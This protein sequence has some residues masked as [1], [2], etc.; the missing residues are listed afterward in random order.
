M[1]KYNWII[2]D[3]TGTIKF[4]AKR[5][6]SFD[7]AEEYLSAFF[8]AEGMDYEEWR[9]EYYIIKDES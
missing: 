1:T 9:Q 4:G 2:Q 3:W 7:D 8:D 5:F 6:K